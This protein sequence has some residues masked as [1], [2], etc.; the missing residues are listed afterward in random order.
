MNE[1][2]AMV[3]INKILQQLDE[4]DRNRVVNYFYLK[5]TEYPSSVLEH[6]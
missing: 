2:K 4:Q 6:I 1:L 5:Y 3:K